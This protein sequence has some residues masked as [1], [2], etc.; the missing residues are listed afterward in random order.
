MK[1]KSKIQQ[2]SSQIKPNPRKS[3]A[4]PKPRQKPAKPSQPAKPKSESEASPDVVAVPT[5]TEPSL[6][7]AAQFAE[8]RW[9][10]GPAWGPYKGGPVGDPQG[11]RVP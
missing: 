11:E 10:G 4:K 8:P 9:R 7:F 6:Q 1:A 3:Q 5:A 2:K